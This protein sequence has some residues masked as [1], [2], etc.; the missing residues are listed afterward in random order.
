MNIQ[1]DPNTDGVDNDPVVPAAAKPD[2]DRC[3]TTDDGM[4]P[5]VMIDIETLGKST[6]ALALSLAAVC[7]D[8][9]SNHVGPTFHMHIDA[10]MAVRNGA[11]MDVSTVLWWM[12]QSEEA[13]KAIG[14]GQHD[15]VPEAL[16]LSMLSSWFHTH[17]IG[18]VE[19]WA[20][21]PQF[22]LR[23]IREMAERNGGMDLP[24]QHWK[25]CCLRTTAGELHGGAASIRPR[26][27]LAHDALEDAIAQAMW[28]QAIRRAK[29]GF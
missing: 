10:E 12:R 14:E 19:V 9:D 21:P 27:R 22:D 16:V 17:T 5:A 29:R 1:L 3:P 23:I 28:L 2:S 8:P 11:R 4:W 7:F 13:R 6:N 15:S 24:W 25:E 20:L 18:P 26:P